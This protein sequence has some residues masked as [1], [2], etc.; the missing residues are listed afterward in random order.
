M[1]NNYQ[2]Y[3][4]HTHVIVNVKLYLAKYTNNILYDHI[5]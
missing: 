5:I 2:L 1:S 4:P 3:T